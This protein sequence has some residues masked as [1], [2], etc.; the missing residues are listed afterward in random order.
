MFTL[1]EDHL[2]SLFTL[3]NFAIPD[4][5]M[6][7]FGL[8]G[9]MP[10]DET[11]TDFKGEHKL[12]F[13][14]PN[15]TH[16]R[17]TI[18][19]WKPGSGFAVFPGSTVPH[20]RVIETAIPRNGVGVNQMAYCYLSRMA[21]NLDHRYFKG[22]HGLSSNLGPHRAFRNESRQ[23][24]WRT[25][26]DL[27]FQGDDRVETEPVFDNLHCA[28]QSTV[29][30]PKYSSN[31]CQVVAGEAGVSITKNQTAERGPWKK[32]VLNAYGLSQARFAYALFD[33][34]EAQRTVELGA[35]SRSPTVRFGSTGELAAL[36]QRALVAAGFDLGPA[37]ADGVFGP[38]SFK[39]LKDAQQRK[40]SIDSV[41]GVFGPST[42]EALGIAWP[43]PASAGGDRPTAGDGAMPASGDAAGA[44][45]DDNFDPALAAGAAGAAAPVTETSDEFAFAPRRESAGNGKMRWVFVDPTDGR[46]RYL[47]GEVR[48]GQFRGLVRIKG[49]GADEGNAEYKFEEYVPE[50]GDWAAFIDPTGLGESQRSFTCL[51]SYDRAAFTFGFYQFAA[52]TPKDNLILLFRSLLALPEAKRYFPDLTLREGKVVR[53]TANGFVDLEG[54]RE[55]SDGMSRRGEQGRFMDYLNTDMKDIDEAERRA[56]ARLIHWATHSP[57]HRRAQVLTSIEHAKRKLQTAHRKLQADH[58]SG[59]DGQSMAVCAMA[60]DVLHQGRGGEDTYKK[61]ARALRS[62]NKVDALASIGDT[63]TFHDRIVQVRGRIKELLQKPPYASLKFKASSATFV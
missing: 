39:T 3:A 43:K 49:F 11:G 15:Y 16:M 17:C 50:F 35:S 18:G 10:L 30:A 55:R 9:C 6:I 48:F 51:N 7:F 45:Q 44:S 26:D 47:G 21:P 5:P 46:T 33:G 28:R 29:S 57:G 8:R 62:S 2:R 23:P 12:E 42:A 54:P 58:N 36:A 37:G 4:D 20:R 25:A 14:G 22:D 19:Q 60:G 31:G 1:T 38:T 56:G 63:E 61:I 40:L 41:D 52:H 24:V 13:L 34:R 27:D 53:I 59:L 32:F